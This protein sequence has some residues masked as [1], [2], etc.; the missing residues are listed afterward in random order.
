MRILIWNLHRGKELRYSS[1]RL[2]EAVNSFGNVDLAGFIE[3]DQDFPSAYSVFDVDVL[4]KETGLQNKTPEHLRIY[5]SLSDGFMGMTWMSQKTVEISDV[6]AR[7]L[8]SLSE[9]RGVLEATVSKGNLRFRAALSHMSLN[10]KYRKFQMNEILKGLAKEEDF[11]LAGDFNEWRKNGKIIS[12]LKK[13]RFVTELS[14]RSFPA[15]W[16]VFP[17]DRA[18]ATLGL[19]MIPLDVPKLPWKK[20]S[21]HRPLFFEIATA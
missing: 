21:D 10:C 4:E 14:A 20:L 18:F 7:N 16:P 6:S 1:E 13:R 3:F 12:T 8:P 5:K 11:L 19:Q 9:P 15:R 17:L 2:A